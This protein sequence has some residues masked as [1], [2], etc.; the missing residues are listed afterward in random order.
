MTT[1]ELFRKKSEMIWSLIRRIQKR[2]RDPFCVCIDEEDYEPFDPEDEDFYEMSCI[3]IRLMGKDCN[4]AL[5]TMAS[6]A[7]PLY[8]DSHD[9]WI[10]IKPAIKYIAHFTT[11]KSMTKAETKTF[12]DLDSFYRMTIENKADSNLALV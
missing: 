9:A 3:D 5:Q 4:N 11:S 8:C 12:E 10:K 6:Y 1:N 2:V 7:Y